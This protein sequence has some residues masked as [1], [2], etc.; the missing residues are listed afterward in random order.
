MTHSATWPVKLLWA[1]LYGVWLLFIK[2]A[3]SIL[4]I[5]TQAFLGQLCALMALFL[6]WAAGPTYGLTLLAGLFCFLAARHFLDSFDEPYARTLAYIWGYFGAALTWLLSHWLLFY[7]VVAQPTLLLSVVGYGLAILYYLDHSKRL[8]PGLRRQIV[9]VMVA[10]VVVIVAF[11][12][13][14]NK[15]V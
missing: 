9:F 2:P 5:S 13:W 15:V 7:R 6:V 3:G 1:V 8:N 12:D 11:S 10:I 14:G 4:M